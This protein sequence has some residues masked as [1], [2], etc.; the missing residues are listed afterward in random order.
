MKD[1]KIALPSLKEAKLRKKY[2]I[3]TYSN[4]GNYL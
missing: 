3:K 2:D 4:F 1:I